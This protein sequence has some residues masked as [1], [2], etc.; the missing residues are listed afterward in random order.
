MWHH[1]ADETIDVPQYEVQQVVVDFMGFGTLKERSS[2]VPTGEVR[3]V[4]HSIWRCGACRA[5]ACGQQG[6]RPATACQKCGAPP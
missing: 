4:T 3:Q 6:Q 5:L 2:T 1:V